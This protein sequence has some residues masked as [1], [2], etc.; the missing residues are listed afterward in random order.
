MLDQEWQLQH[1]VL[2]TGRVWLPLL[3]VLYRCPV[4]VVGGYS[5]LYPCHAAP[6]VLLQDPTQ[7]SSQVYITHSVDGH[8]L[9]SGQSVLSQQNFT[10]EFWSPF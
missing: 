8:L 4:P 9:Y 6:S 2:Q 10:P 5:L 7:A 1:H 3:A